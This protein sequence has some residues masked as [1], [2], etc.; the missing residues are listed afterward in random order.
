MRLPITVVPQVRG[1]DHTFRVSAKEVDPRTDN[2][3]VNVSIVARRCFRDE[4]S[5]LCY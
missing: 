2:G 5:T 1:G 4:A 3:S